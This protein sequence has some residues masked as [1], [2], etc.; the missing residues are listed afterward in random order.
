MS[1]DQHELLIKMSIPLFLV[2][3]KVEQEVESDTLLENIK[4]RYLR[5]DPIS[6][7]P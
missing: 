7:R 6:V 4:L 3:Y 2:P 5:Q 1:R